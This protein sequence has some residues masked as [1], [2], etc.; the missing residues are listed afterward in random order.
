MNYP[1]LNIEERIVISQLSVSGIS[2]REIA[3]QLDRSQSTISRELKRNSYK[4]EGND[5]A[6]PMTL[7]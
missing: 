2:I 6:S 4:T 7:L 5:S 1:H 3:K